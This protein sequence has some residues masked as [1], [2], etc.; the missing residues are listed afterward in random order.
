[1][2]A[3]C[4]LL[5]SGP[6]ATLEKY[7]LYAESNNL[8]GMFG[9]MSDRLLDELGDVKVKKDNERFSDAVAKGN[10]KMQ[11]ISETVIGDTAKIVFFYKDAAKNDSVRLGFKFVKQGGDWKIDGYGFGDPDGDTPSAD[12]SQTPI[13]TPKDDIEPPPPPDTETN[14]VSK[15]KR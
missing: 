13:P 5:G 3:G 4:S 11:I 15:P 14:K 2:S 1:M 7:L 9:L 12:E 8:D 10:H 6:K